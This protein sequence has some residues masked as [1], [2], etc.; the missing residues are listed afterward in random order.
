[1]P[2]PHRPP[3]LLYVAWGFPP[4]R[5]GGVFRALATAN[6]F[7]R[8]GW[9]VTVLTADREAIERY[10][11]SDP[12]L[13]RHI[14][15]R[16]RVVRLP[17][18]WP[19]LET[20]VRTYSWLR[21]H[22]P[23]NWTKLHHHRN[24][25]GFP[26]PNYGTWQSTLQ[27]EALRLHDRDPVDL[28][29]ATANPNVDFTAA[30]VLHRR[31]RVPFVMDYRDAWLL[32]VFS[33]D[34]LHPEGSRAARWERKLVAAAREIWFVNEP[35]RAWHRARYPHS[36]DRMQVVPN[37]LDPELAP[38]GR[39]QARDGD[40]GLTYGY[41][42]TISPKVP[43]AEL[44]EGWRW[45]RARDELVGSSRM[46]LHGHLGYYA[47]PRGDLSQLVAQA[48]DAQVDYAGPVAKTEVGDVY[49]S[50]DVLLLALGKGRYVTSGKVYEYLATG[51]P[52]VSV[53]DPGNAASEVLRGYPMWFP[54]S[55]LSVDTIGRTLVQAGHTAAEA[56][57]ELRKLCLDFAAEHTRD[58]QLL[59]RIRALTESIQAVATPDEA[60]VLEIDAAG[61]APA[62]S[63]NTVGL[64]AS[65]ASA[66][67]R[68]T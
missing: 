55:D 44:I 21:V 39:T 58:R 45:A 35:I 40:G 37:G 3:H 36:A 10:I 11:G 49:D 51:L 14:D 50:F 25:L 22:S 63:G 28:V 47:I 6:A 12:D 31:R 16:I 7:A 52:I 32:D 46:R 48:R 56:G 54:V 1:M 43:L 68:A 41:L 9:R 13:E 38:R 42:G 64:S 17:F 30:W 34:M 8:S 24:S 65:L 57:P 59:P 27:R 15:P 26:E 53:H 66:P 23:N 33:G 67:R 62:P 20:D 5:S 29:V 2:A 61:A 4:S 18:H 19:M 60:P